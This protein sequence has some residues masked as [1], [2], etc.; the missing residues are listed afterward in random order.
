MLPEKVYID[1]EAPKPIKELKKL[2]FCAIMDLEA[3]EKVLLLEMLKGDRKKE[4][5]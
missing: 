2:A 3:D 1:N 4:E 5:I